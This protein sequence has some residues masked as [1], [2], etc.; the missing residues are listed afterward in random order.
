MD[1]EKIA[2]DIAML[3]DTISQPLPKG[4]V[5]A[6]MEEADYRSQWLARVS[7]MEADA[8]RVVDVKR[9][10]IAERNPDMTATLLREKLASGTADETKLVFLTRRTYTTMVTQIDVIRSMISYEKEHL[11]RGLQ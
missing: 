4:N 11:K 5:E 8:Q 10:E 9:G 3:N 6:L 7:E 2:Q 1:P